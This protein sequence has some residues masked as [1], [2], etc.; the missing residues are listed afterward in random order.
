MLYRRLIGSQRQRAAECL[1]C[2]FPALQLVFA[3]A[4]VVIC[5]EVAGVLR[6][7]LPVQPGGVRKL[8]GMMQHARL[9][10]EVVGHVGIWNMVECKDSSICGK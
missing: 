6:E 3:G 9:L 1:L 8:A 5:T 2:L 10:K 4:Q 7:H